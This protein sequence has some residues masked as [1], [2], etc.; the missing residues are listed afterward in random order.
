MNSLLK[1]DIKTILI[2]LLG[3]FLIYKS[4][5]TK[6]T[7]KGETIRVDG[8][9]YELLKH[10]VDT[11]YIEHTQTVTKKGKDI[12][13]DTT[14]YVPVPMSVDTLNILKSY[15][16][17]KVFKD[18]LKLA[19]SLGF[20]FVTDTI[21][22]NSLYSRTWNTKVRKMKIKETT[23]VKE[24]PK[25][26]VFFGFTGTVNKVDLFN[27]A[28]LQFT[29]KNKADVLYNLNIG[30]GTTRQ[31]GMTPFIGVGVHWLIKLR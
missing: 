19:D 23:I 28:S 16:S 9:K 17:K 11:E 24:L 22:Q 10:T 20:I 6:G 5:N 26:Q 27:S 25:N 21:S 30:L 14:I 12:Y 4:C 18:T 8:K 29:L 3:V 15:F 1:L 13:H 2:L 7:Q 31:P